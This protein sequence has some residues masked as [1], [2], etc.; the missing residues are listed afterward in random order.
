VALSRSRSQA[1]RQT[2]DPGIEKPDAL[3]QIE[4]DVIIQFLRDIEETGSGERDKVPTSGA[5]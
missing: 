2:R 5:V 4:A 3:S 1:T